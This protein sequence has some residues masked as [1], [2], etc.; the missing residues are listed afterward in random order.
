[1]LNALPAPHVA[2]LIVV[3]Q[4][5]THQTELCSLSVQAGPSVVDTIERW[6]PS[7]V[8]G[9][10]TTWADLAKQDLSQRDTGSV[11]MWFNTGDCAHEAHIRR[12][13]VLG[14]RVVATKE[15]RVRTDGSVFIDGLGSSEM[16][17]SHFFITHTKDTDRYGR[18]VGRPYSFCDLKVFDPDGNEL[19]N[20]QVGELG[21]KSPT[22]AMGYWN[23]S[24]QHFRTRLNG[25]FLTGD[26]VYRDDA[27]Y[28]YHMDRLVDS[29]DLGDGKR[30]YTAMSEERILAACPDVVD[31]TVSAVHEDGKIVTDVMLQLTADANPDDPRT[32]RIMAA[33]DPSVAATVRRI[34][35]VA[36]ESIPV[37]PTGKVR[38]FQLRQLQTQDAT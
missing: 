31:C 27:G 29:V 6:Q 37:G 36:D 20:Y 25:Y 38:K 11:S 21:T 33:L 5:L 32:D 26:L 22:N 35:V 17:H 23:N 3:N 16:G 34:D 9:F 14:H 12:L 1:M 10:A 19:P 4:A 2:T 7:S 8:F 13:V 24:A 15:G 28:F 18:C 30:L